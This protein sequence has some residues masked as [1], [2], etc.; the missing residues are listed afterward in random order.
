MILPDDDTKAY[1]EHADGTCEF[2]QYVDCDRD[3]DMAITAG[4]TVIFVRGDEA[5]MNVYPN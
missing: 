5:T 1:V 3:G 4:G 2:G